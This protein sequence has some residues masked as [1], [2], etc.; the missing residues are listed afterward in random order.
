ML[1]LYNLLDETTVAVERALRLVKSPTPKVVTLGEYEAGLNQVDFL[2]RFKTALRYYSAIFES[3]E[4]SLTR[5]STEHLR[6]ES[7]LLGR[8]IYGVV[9]PE[10]GPMRQERMEEKEQWRVLTEGC[11]FESVALSHYAMNQAKILLWN[12]NY[13]SSYSL[14]ESPLGFL[15]LAWNSVSLLTVSSW[16]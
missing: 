3:L 4:P 15:S 12:Y 2:N 8:R 13:S 11:G 7:L 1:Q 5:D 6:I 9:G 10:E 14:V 16:R